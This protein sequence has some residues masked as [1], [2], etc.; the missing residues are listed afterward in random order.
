[1]VGLLVRQAPDGVLGGAWTALVNYIARSG[2][3]PALPAPPID[4]AFLA[5]SA[6]IASN[7]LCICAEVLSALT[8]L[9]AAG[10]RHPKIAYAVVALGIAELTVFAWSNV[11]TFDI[12]KTRMPPGEQRFL[13]AHPGDYRILQLAFPP[14]DVIGSST[15]DIWGYDPSVMGRYAEFVFFTQGRNPDDASTYLDFT[16]DS[17]LLGIVRCKYIFRRAGDNRLGL[18]IIKNPLP[19]AFIAKNWTGAVGRASVFAAI[20]QTGFDTASTAVLETADI[21]VPRAGSGAGSVDVTT[22]TSDTI[23][24]QADTPSPSLLVITDPYSR[25]WRATALPGSA[26]SAYAVLPCDYA[27]MAIPL[28]A[29]RNAIELRYLPTG[30]IPALWTMLVG[31]I[32]YAGIWVATMRAE[33]RLRPAS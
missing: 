29:G 24:I 3:S 20:G 23:R 30:F 12:A 25:Y 33:L 6:A 2:E 8:A 10:I 22:P 31:W 17:P 16:K 13:A 4:P 32:V 14:D 7:G 28:A 27:I 18:N 1:V 26:R 15:G 11:V 9:L 19:H 21:P 5:R